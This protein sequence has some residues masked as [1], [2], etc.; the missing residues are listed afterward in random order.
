MELK[1]FRKL[2]EH[3]DVLPIVTE[4]EC[5]PEAWL[6]QTGRQ[7]VRVQREALAIPI[8]GLRRSKRMGR[9]RRDVHESR[10]TTLSRSFPAVR[11]FIEAVADELDATLS[12]AKIF[13]LPPAA[14]VHAHVDRGAYY[15]C[16]DRYHLVIE[17]AGCPMRAGDEV[18]VMRPGELWWF[19]NKTDHEAWNDSDSPRIHLIFDLEPGR[20]EARVRRPR[21][22]RAPASRGELAASGTTAD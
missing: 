1:N 12:R 17:S 21:R 19:D 18:V 4:L 9:D 22:E 13:S 16:R 20:S 8:R 10:Y 15:A 7:R 3:V 2:K 6:A 11:R 14:R 5:Q